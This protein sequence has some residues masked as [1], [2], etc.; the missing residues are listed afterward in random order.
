MPV[1]GNKQPLFNKLPN[2]QYNISYWAPE[3]GVA[4]ETGYVIQTFDWK[5]CD[6]WALGAIFAE[7]LRMGET[8]FKQHN[9]LDLLSKVLLITECR[10][11]DMNSS[12]LRHPD[13]PFK[14][15]W[16]TQGTCSLEKKVN[17]YPG[18][19]LI[20][21]VLQSAGENLAKLSLDLLGQMLSFEPT[22]RPTCV[23]LLNHP[24]FDSSTTGMERNPSVESTCTHPRGLTDAN[25]VE[26]VMK[27]CGGV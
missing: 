7:M 5:K 12:Y 27:K 18:S 13:F 26:F 20:P 23:Q 3:L 22:T 1:R 10:P 6:V 14:S 11:A 21:T 24:F 9:A 16:P 25:L 17:F 15:R 19:I 4:Q 2:P 8:L